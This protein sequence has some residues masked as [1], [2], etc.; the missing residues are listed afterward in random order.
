MPTLRPISNAQEID[1]IVALATPPGR[2]GIGV[3]RI[4]GPVAL[5]IGQALSGQQPKPRL[6]NLVSFRDAQGQLLDQGLLLYFPGPASFTGEDVIEL[7][8]HGGPVVMDLLLQA[9]LA[10][11]A[12]LARPGEFSERAFL[13]DKLDLAQAEAIAD[14]IDSASRAAALGAARSLSGEFS[15]HIDALAQALLELRIYVE[16]AI[17]FPEEEVDFLAEG[18]VVQR[19]EALLAQLAEIQQSA[20]QGALLTEG[21]RLALAGRPN[22]GKSSLLNRLAGYDRAIVTDIPGTTRDS[23]SEQLTLE[24]I[25]ITLVDTAGLR[26]TADL[27]EQ[28]GIARAHVQITQADQVLLLTDSDDPAQWQALIAEQRL[29]TAKLSIV[30]NKIDLGASS[31]P[32]SWQGLAVLPISALSG[33]G[34]PA[35]IAHIKQL[36]G[37]R[38]SEGNFSARRRHL[39]ALARAERALHNGLA[40]LQERGAGELLAE[41]LRLAHEA[42]GEIVGV[43]T[44][45]ALLG[46]IF[47]SFCIG[48]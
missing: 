21:I 2:G 48:K 44:P 33:A 12:R 30:R 41:D 13:N 38:P 28:A 15:A 47:G 43:V 36:A 27:V 24:G 7:Q 37:F 39:D 31:A 6:A 46:E 19:V 40:Q 23:L 42:L 16:A 25:P 5:A 14:L 3:I 20:Q 35:L 45:D 22:V 9:C 11:G 8:G 1:T 17:D 4:S 10:L 34:I 26:A 29:P 32:T 18:Q